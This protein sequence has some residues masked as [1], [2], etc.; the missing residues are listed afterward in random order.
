MDKK[1]QD[2]ESKNTIWNTINMLM[3]SVGSSV[4]G[5]RD[6]LRDRL[7][8]NSPK[9]TPSAYSRSFEASRPTMRQPTQT[10]TAAPTQA[11]TPTQQPVPTM[12]PGKGLAM[13]YL[14]GKLPPG[15]T[16]GQ[17]YPATGDE[18][19]MSGIDESEKLRQGLASLL[20]LQGFFESNLGRTTPNIFGVKPGGESQHFGSPQE[21]LNY[22]LGP[23]VLGGGATPQMNLLSSS[24]PISRDDITSLYSSYNPESYYLEDLLKIL[25]P[26]G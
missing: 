11:L 6:Y 2:T 10:P 22:Q 15:Q 25:F 9:S 23:S 26:E 21:A 3:N 19:F 14:Q 5:Q 17:A 12:A 20:M 18:G 7:Y 24:E 8:K 4:R 1:V 16:M 13:D